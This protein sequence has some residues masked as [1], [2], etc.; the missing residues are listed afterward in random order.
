MS[1][2]SDSLPSAM[3]LGRDL[4]HT[5]LGARRGEIIK[6]PSEWTPVISSAPMASALLHQV[7]GWAR[8]LAPSASRAA[9]M[10]P[11]APAQDQ[12]GLYAACRNLWVISWAIGEAQER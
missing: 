8:E 1:R 2:K 10:S 4:L 7:G 3:T 5:H 6:Y 11:S 9:A 12:R